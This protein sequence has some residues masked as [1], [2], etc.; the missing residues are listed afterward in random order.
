MNK[1]DRVKLIYFFSVSLL[2]FLYGCIDTNVQVIPSNIDTRSQIKF[3]NLA[4]SAG[5]ATIKVFDNKKS[6]INTSSAVA[7]GDEYPGSGVSFLDIPSGSTGTISYT[8]KNVIDSLKLFDSDLKLRIFI[9]EDGGGNRTIVKRSERYI[10]QQKNTA[11]GKT[12]YPANI[13]SF[14]FFNGAGDTTLDTIK[15][16]GTNG[17]ATVFDTTITPSSSLSTGDGTVYFQL[18][19]APNYSI[20]FISTDGI[21]TNYP[22]FVPQSQG[23]YT[24]VVYGLKT[25]YKY[26]VYTDD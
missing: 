21:L 5:A 1:A 15:I 12:L 20:T 10:E 7:V 6:N 3:V 16:K 2:I 8:N 11:I 17:S 18:K 4:T 13:S 26:K 19:T 22:N 23:R 14:M 24:A 25:G 9:V